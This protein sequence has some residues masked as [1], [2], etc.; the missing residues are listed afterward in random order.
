VSHWY[1]QLV[2]S[3]KIQGP[4][5]RG[6]ISHNYRV[7]S[8]RLW[9]KTFVHKGSVVDVC[10]R[11]GSWI[12]MAPHR[13]TEGSVYRKTRKRCCLRNFACVDPFA[14]SNSM[15]LWR[16]FDSITSSRCQSYGPSNKK[17][18]E[19][20]RLHTN[21]HIFFVYLSIYVRTNIRRPH[22]RKLDCI[23]KT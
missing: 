20:N 9:E 2:P 22:T 21:V 5:G 19:K 14:C 13:I 17:Q 10:M 4:P 3:N 7:I 6:D 18:M 15:I 23:F 16:W 8:L 11:S 12:E 1:Q